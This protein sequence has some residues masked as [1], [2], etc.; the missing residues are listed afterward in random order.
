MK[1]FSRF[2]TVSTIVAL[3]AISVFSDVNAGIKI[4]EKDD[5]SLEIYGRIQPRFEWKEV[6]NDTSTGATHSSNDFYIRRTRFGINAA[7]TKN[8][9]GKL[10][11]KYDNYMQEG[12]TSTLKLENAYAAFDYFDSQFIIEFGLDNSVFSREGQLSDSKFLF[13]DRSKIINKIQSE[14]LA[15]N[16]T[17]L[18]L[19]GKLIDK[20]LEYGL[21][22]YEGGDVTS[23]EGTRDDQ[24]QYAAGVT[25]HIFEP[26]SMAGSHIGDGKQ[27]LTVGTYV[28]S[29]AHRTTG[30]TS[31]DVM[32]YGADVFSQFSTFTF[33]GGYFV[34][35][36]DFN[37]NMD[38][39]NKGFYVESAYLLPQKVGVGE[40]EFAAR[41]QEYLPATEANAADEK[42]TS[43]GVNYYIKK[44]DVKVQTTYNINKKDAAHN[45]DPGDNL[46][47]QLQF[48]W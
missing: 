15:D 7:N 11:W 29:Q 21:G 40:M 9:K 26:E 38:Y 18:H 22:I 23:T 3:L 45:Y 5:I 31:W 30:T 12:S 20:H 37:N 4:Y 41:Y 39:S 19:K 48:A 33:S 47:V 8:I 35:G 17:G 44:H 46:V 6:D 28:A 36:K 42:Q 14:G 2:L 27:Y 43:L 25:Y 13:D 24:L 34:V 32:T 1:I 16:A 10:E